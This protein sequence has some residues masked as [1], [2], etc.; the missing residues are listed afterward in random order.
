VAFVLLVWRPPARRLPMAAASIA[1]TAL[2]VVALAGSGVK[3]G[4]CNPADQRGF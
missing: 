3:R 1:V 2:L 4:S